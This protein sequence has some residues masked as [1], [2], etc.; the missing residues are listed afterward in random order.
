MKLLEDLEK[1][2]D[3]ELT[4]LEIG[5]YLCGKVAIER[6][7]SDF[8]DFKR[9]KTQARILKDAYGNDAYLVVEWN[10]DDVVKESTFHFKKD[11][12]NNILGMVAS[13][14]SREKLVPIFCS[15]S[16]YA[17]YIIKSLCEKGNEEKK[18]D[19][20][21]SKPRQKKGDQVIHFL[22]G[23]PYIDDVMAK[24]LLDEFHTVHNIMNADLEDLRKVH[25]IGKRKGQIIYEIL[26]LR[27][28]SEKM[29]DDDNWYEEGW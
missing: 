21:K 27:E 22:C 1:W 2:A 11:M 29:G 5:D 13:L 14:C 3:I 6:K 12:K 7:R 8:L 18:K 16:E 10:L 23:L 26:R 15:N 9:L 19:A 28:P 25:G 17:S 4:K 24:R 20:K